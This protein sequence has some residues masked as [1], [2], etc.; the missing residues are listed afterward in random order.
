MQKE[1]D[2]LIGDIENL[3][4]A[5]TGLGEVQAQSLKNYPEQTILNKLDTLEYNFEDLTPDAFAKQIESIC[6]ETLAIEERFNND[7]KKRINHKYPNYFNYLNSLDDE[8]LLEEL[9]DVNHNLENKINDIE[10]RRPNKLLRRGK[11]LI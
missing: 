5:L 4:Q 10:G 6:K 2:N 9:E 11:A 8:E 7:F 3:E 1:V